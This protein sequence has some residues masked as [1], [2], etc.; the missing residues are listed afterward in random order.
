MTLGA[1]RRQPTEGPRGPDEHDE[2]KIEPVVTDPLY[3][4]HAIA[5]T[6]PDR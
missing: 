2:A 3:D 5:R 1:G 6:G 4:A